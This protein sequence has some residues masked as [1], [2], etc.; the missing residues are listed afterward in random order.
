M[1]EVFRVAVW[2][3]GPARHEK[4]RSGEAS[5]SAWAKAGLHGFDPKTAEDWAVNI[6]IKAATD[7]EAA[8]EVDRITRFD[9]AV[10]GWTWDNFGK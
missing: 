2:G 8:E 7:R 3:S 1:A 9:P 4:I 6:L 10:K 5:F